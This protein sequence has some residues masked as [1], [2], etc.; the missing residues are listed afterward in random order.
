MKRRI[1]SERF[2]VVYYVFGSGNQHRKDMTDEKL[3]GSSS[4]SETNSHQK[5]YGFQ[6]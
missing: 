3:D 2:E 6:P 1:E 4:H 5:C